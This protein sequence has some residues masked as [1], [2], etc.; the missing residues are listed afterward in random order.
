[1]GP[2]GLGFGGVHYDSTQ[3][4]VFPH[5]CSTDALPSSAVEHRPGNVPPRRS[6]RTRWNIKPFVIGG[7]GSEALALVASSA[8]L[9]EVRRPKLIGRDG[10]EWEAPS[11]NEIPPK[12][13]GKRPGGKPSLKMKTRNREVKVIESYIFLIKIIVVVR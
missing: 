3:L 2:P 7:A 4:I 5:Q 11:D 9:H 13:L 1:M 8:A 6:N 12:N 10:W